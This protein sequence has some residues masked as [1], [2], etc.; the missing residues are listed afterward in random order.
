MDLNSTSAS[1][2]IVEAESGGLAWT[3][4]VSPASFD[5]Q[6]LLTVASRRFGGPPG[7][8][9]KTP[10]MGTVSGAICRLTGNPVRSMA[11]DPLQ[12]WHDIPGL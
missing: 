2:E 6:S 9:R 10:S 3:D 12:G 8:D 11:L 5:A 4:N 1:D 7:S